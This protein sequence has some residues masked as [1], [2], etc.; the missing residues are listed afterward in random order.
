MKL[1]FR[2]KKQKE[3][4]DKFISKIKKTF[5]KKRIYFPFLSLV[6][7]ISLIYVSILIL[8]Y[9]IQKNS[10]NVFSYRNLIVK[11]IQKK[12]Q[13][14]VEIGISNFSLF[15]GIIFEDIKV[16]NEEDFSSN[17]LFF[18]SERLDIRFS[19]IL[20]PTDKIDK[21]TFYNSNISLDL[22]SL[23]SEDFFRYLFD[24]DIR[25]IEFKNLEL[26]VF[27]SGQDYFRSKKNISLV[28][29]K[30]GSGY[31][32][33]L[34]NSQII[35]KS[36][37]GNGKILKLDDEIKLTSR[38]NFSDYNLS[39]L[40]GFSSAI[41][42]LQPE[43]GLV[44]GFILLETN[45]KELKIDGSMD[46]K[47]FTGGFAVFNNISSDSFNIH[48]KF[49]FFR[50]NTPKGNESYYK[51]TVSSPEFIY[52]EQIFTPENKLKKIDIEFQVDDFKKITEKL[53][54]TDRFR[55]SGKLNLKLKIEETNKLTDVML[56]NGSGNLKN[57][58]L[59]TTE[60]LLDIENT[61]L[62]FYWNNGNL[63]SEFQGNLFQKKFDGSLTSPLSFSKLSG[64]DFISL[65]SNSIIKLN[66]EELILE[67]FKPIYNDLKSRIEADIK[68]RQEKM[69]PESYLVLSDFY[70]LFL[71]KS[72]SEF[73]LNIEKVRNG[74]NGIDFGEY[75]L[76]LK[77]N[78]GIA[79][80]NISS[81]NDKE[82]FNFRSN[83]YL[84]RRI[85]NLDFNLSINSFFY[86]DSLF[87][88]CDISLYA[89]VFSF[90]FNL[91][92]FG[93][94]F[95]EFYA[96]RSLSGDFESSNGVYISNGI[97]NK[98]SMGE[99]L[100]NQKFSNTKFQFNAYS[101]DL[102]FRN[103]SITTNDLNILGNSNSLRGEQ[104][105]TFYI[106]NK[107]KQKTLTFQKDKFSC[108]S[109]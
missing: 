16:S 28:L 102:F 59:K 90:N 55:M 2:S 11:T 42:S 49:S 70:K 43:S 71:E 34:D 47:K 86:F 101:S 27:N 80:L 35:Y 4:L 82:K 13:K 17:K 50:E 84:D 45:S 62:S 23:I 52:D 73:S 32:W 26:N 103:I 39:D 40:Y 46:F 76:N 106:N 89:D 8:E 66:Y 81:K 61:Q 83:I 12:F 85:P 30:E 99:Y 65:N 31:I 57:F 14:A 18:I 77:L 75:L 33:T 92:T 95:S 19:S 21:L 24:L 97:L 67:N 48:S 25:E 60:A 38:I 78:F 44:D 3:F 74:A 36:L 10:L 6:S 54:L 104:I 51:R 69:L 9:R 5:F 88:F 107:E 58:S 94:N 1:F 29:K 93:N 98:I 68:E 63:T 105:Y 53:S 72:K 7:L 100:N 79:N 41:A 91:S 96:N 15:D 20:N 37:D 64:S 109:K 22:K 108:Y 56:I 87:D